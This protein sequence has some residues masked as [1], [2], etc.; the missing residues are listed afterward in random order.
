MEF[1][2]KWY[3][4]RDEF[5]T[6]PPATEPERTP[7]AESDL[8]AA[9]DSLELHQTYMERC[10]TARQIGQSVRDLQ[11]ERDKLLAERE[12]WQEAWIAEYPEATCPLERTVWELKEDADEECSESTRKIPRRVLV[13]FADKGDVQ[14]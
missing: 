10:R 4:R 3:P 14:P 2:K 11:A 8:M 1:Y 7:P 12:G 5:P 6:A 13:R 9:I